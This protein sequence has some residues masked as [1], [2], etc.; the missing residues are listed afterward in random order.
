MRSLFILLFLVHKATM[1]DVGEK[2]PPRRRKESEIVVARPGEEV[3]LICPIYGS[4]QPIIEWEKDGEV[5][6]YTWTRVK[7]NKSYLKLR[8]A[9]S[10]DTGVFYCRGV[11]GF[12]SVRVRIE[13]IV[14]DSI[15]ENEETNL[16][17]AAPV[18]TKKT[19]ALHNFIKKL[20]GDSLELPC[21]ALGSPRPSLSWTHEGRSL[22]SGPTLSIPSLSESDSG[23]YVCVASNMAGSTVVE[24]SVTV[25]SPRVELPS[26][27]R[28]TNTS[29]R[30]GETA[31]LQCR[32]QSSLPPSVQWL[33][34]VEQG[35][36]E[37]EESS[38]SLGNMELVTVQREEDRSG[39]VTLGQGR[40]LDTLVIDHVRTTHGG[41]Y[42]CFA[43]NTAGGF[44]YQSAHLEI[45]APEQMETSLDEPEDQQLFLG[46]VIGLV[47]VVLI[48]LAAIFFCLIKTRHKLLLPEYAESQ[49]AIIYQK[50]VCD[51]SQ[52]YSLPPPD[53]V[54]WSSLQKS[55]LPPP[56]P[57][58][59][60]PSQPPTN[61]GS[62]IYDLP[63]SHT[64][65]QARATPH[66]IVHYSPLPTHSP[67]TSRASRLTSLPSPSGRVASLPASP[68][69]RYCSPLPGRT[70]RPQY[71]TQYQN[72]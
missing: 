6:D 44:N 1:E 23:L 16:S 13:L 26:I 5:V 68:R 42:V 30:P 7:T 64:S 11:N 32:V 41:L 36:E 50:A 20:P 69:Q 28:V 46:L 31:V 47:S 52:Q 40:Y 14:T 62:N 2:G 38:L 48:L 49:R 53:G 57:P 61:T 65:P 25:E 56:L 4:P 21:Q 72:L 10:S 67:A 59:Q 71:V 60:P 8:G 63:F 27:S 37:Q 12:G 58:Y 17:L 55:G 70:D 35:E 9:Q 3:K 19:E 54:S 15:G 39:L 66:H 29:A 45:L 51:P 43:T 33:K 18:F 22:E 34:K 24:F